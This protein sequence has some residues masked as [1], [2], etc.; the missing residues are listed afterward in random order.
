MKE[1]QLFIDGK[2]VDNGS[3]EMFDN[4]NPSTEE[5]VSRVP[6]ATEADVE[7]AVNAAY[8]AQ[9]DWAKLPAVERAAWVSKI[10]AGIRAKAD[11]F[12]EIIMEE[13]GKTRGL[14]TV[15]ANFVPDYMDYMAGFAR[16]I[17]GE[18]IESDAP[19]RT[20]SCTRSP[21]ALLRAS[22]RG[23]SP[24]SWSRAKWLPRWLPATPS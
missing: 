12:A 9:K 22:C 10:A 6:K 14:A 15:E 19:T 5:M 11:F 23:T 4:I 20:S 8:E 24:S 7:A 17:E 21:S 13:Q 2:F 18:V 3:R 1:Y 16:H